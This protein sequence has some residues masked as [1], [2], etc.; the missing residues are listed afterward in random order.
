[1]IDT[2]LENKP[3]ENPWRE[4]RL[5]QSSFLLRDYDFDLEDMP[6][7]ADG[8]LPLD[9]DPKIAWAKV[10][11]SDSPIEVNHADR[12][13]LLRVPGI[14]PKGVEAILAARRK[15][16]LR[17]LKD[18]KAIGVLAARAAPFILL[19]GRRPMR[20]LSLW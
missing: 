1:V 8:Y 11:L 4:H 3:Q 13:E 6:F 12:H 16:T 15:G 10:N 9:I 14:G 7:T 2:P 5:Y 18:L 20:Q 19:D 17:D